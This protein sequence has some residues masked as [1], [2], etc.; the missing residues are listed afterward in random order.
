MTQPIQASPLENRESHRPGLRSG[1]RL[2]LARILAQIDW[3]R[4][5]PLS[6]DLDH[7]AIAMEA[8]NGFAAEWVIARSEAVP[9][10]DELLPVLDGLTARLLEEH[11]AA[12]GAGKRPPLESSPAEWVARLQLAARSADAQG[13]KILQLLAEG[14]PARDAA[15]RLEIG[16]Q[17]AR[18]IVQDARSAWLNPEQMTATAC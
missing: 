16:L 3:Y 1:A 6:F 15:R 11:S 18:R 2:V 12:A 14:F 5:A 10:W 13:P 4:D 9:S 7:H 17:M 8:W